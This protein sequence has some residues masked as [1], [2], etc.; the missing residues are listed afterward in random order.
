MY[1]GFEIDGQTLP[2]LSLNDR[3]YY[4]KYA[5]ETYN[6]HKEI[7]ESKLLDLFEVHNGII[8]VKPIERTWFPSVKSHVFLSHSHAD[9]GKALVLAGFLKYHCD[10]DVFIDSCVWKY[11]ND[12]LRKLDNSFCRKGNGYYDYDCRNIT[13]T[14]VHLILNMALAKMINNTEC[15]LFLN[16][17]NSVYMKQSATSKET[18]SP[19]ICDE[20]L[21]ASLIG[22]RS[23][24]IHRK[25]YKLSHSFSINES[26]QFVPHFIYDIGFMKM[27]CLT[28]SD[29]LDIAQKTGDEYIDKSGNSLAELFLD[30]LYE[31]MDIKDMEALYG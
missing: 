4:E 10:V 16:T 3:Y 28:Y 9:M 22:R 30:S 18:E 6:Q 1:I 7:F 17:D 19:W 11:S 29:L 27:E 15:F 31:R 24:E 25:E 26:Q 20:L 8:E 13:T 21:L 23:K 14:Q 5:L 2:N 12:L